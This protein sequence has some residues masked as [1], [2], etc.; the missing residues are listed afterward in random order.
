M[1]I[2]ATKIWTPHRTH[3]TKNYHFLKNGFND[4]DSI[5]A[6]YGNHLPKQTKLHRLN[7]QENNCTPSSGP[8]AKW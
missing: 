2:L 3:Q 8:S 5:A 1:N 7:L 4:F 6:I